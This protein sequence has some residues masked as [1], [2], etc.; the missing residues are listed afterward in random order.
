MDAKLRISNSDDGNRMNIDAV[1]LT[2]LTQWQHDDVVQLRRRIHRYPELG[3]HL[4]RTRAA[5]LD[6]LQGLDLDIHLSQSTS[7]IVAV[8]TGHKAGSITL[9]RGDMDAL[10][11]PEN[12]GLE[13]SSEVEGRMHACGHD[14]HTAMLS[15]AA[16]LLSLIK[17]QVPGSVVLCFNREKRDREGPLP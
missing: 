3:N 17:D 1:D 6:S 10:P 2:S 16:R 13:Y 4:P 7:G 15:G 14:A 8:L 9:L 5:V 12:T 11:M